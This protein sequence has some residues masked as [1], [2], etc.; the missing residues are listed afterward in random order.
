MSDR[1]W[2]NEARTV[3][4]RLWDTGTVEVAQREAPDHTWGPPILCEEE[5]VAVSSPS[6]QETNTPKNLMREGATAPVMEE[7]RNDV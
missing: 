2:V 4:V 1:L 6:S 5:R 3:F 7:G